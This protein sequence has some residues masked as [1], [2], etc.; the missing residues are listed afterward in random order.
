MLRRIKY[1]LLQFLLTDIC[2]KSDCEKCVFCYKNRINLNNT[3]SILEASAC[4]ED[5]VLT[6]ARRAWGLEK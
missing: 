1:K 6:Q 4:N 5:D 2:V 3:E